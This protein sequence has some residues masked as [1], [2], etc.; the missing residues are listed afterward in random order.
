MVSILAVVILLGAVVPRFKPIFAGTGKAIPLMTQAVL[1]A[2]D[3]LRGY[4]WLM[5]AA[6]ALVI[7]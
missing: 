6:L 2:G 5:L 1:L 7:Y 4:G 3:A